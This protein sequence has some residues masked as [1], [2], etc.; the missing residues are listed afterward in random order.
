M[1]SAWNLFIDVFIMHA[2]RINDFPCISTEHVCVALRTPVHNAQLSVSVISSHVQ[3]VWETGHVLIE[4]KLFVLMSR[5]RGFT[6]REIWF[7][8]IQAFYH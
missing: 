7:L 2:Y 5:Q 4:E 8:T 3:S 1:H 6:L